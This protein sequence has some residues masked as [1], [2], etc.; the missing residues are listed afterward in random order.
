MVKNSIVN[1][2]FCLTLLLT[3][4]ACSSVDIPEEEPRVVVREVPIDTP[5]PIVPSVEQLDL[6]DVQ[7]VIITEENYQEVFQELIDNNQTPVIFG[8]SGK[9]YEN[10]ALNLNDLRSTIQ[11]YQA[12]VAIYEKSYE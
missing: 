3:V 12:I 11:Q 2:L 4:S 7:W 10:L 9:G 6:K 1:V 5:A 8:L